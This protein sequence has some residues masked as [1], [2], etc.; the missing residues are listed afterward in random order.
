V[1]Y[2][3]GEFR[4]FAREFACNDSGQA[5]TEYVLIMTIALGGTIAI[6]KLVFKALD[7]FTVFFGGQL[8]KDLKAGRAQTNVWGN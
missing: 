2:L 8:E 4:K 7:Q 5:I 1:S 6:T 3:I